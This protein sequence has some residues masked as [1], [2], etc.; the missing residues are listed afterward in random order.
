MKTNPE[1]N[2]NADAPGGQLLAWEWEEEPVLLTQ[3]SDPGS[4]FQT[5]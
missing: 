5:P 2:F 3:I 1:V 4:D